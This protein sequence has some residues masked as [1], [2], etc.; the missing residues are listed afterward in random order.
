MASQSIY[1]FY[2]VLDDYKPVMWRRFQ[3]PGNITVARLAYIVMTLFEMT[4]SHLFAVEVPWDENFYKEIQKEDPEMFGVERI[5]TGI[6]PVWRY[7][8]PDL[9]MNIF[10][11]SEEVRVLDA[12]KSS[13]SKAV[14]HSG[15]KLNLNYDFGDNWRVSLT[16][17]SVTQDADLP[18]N[19]LPRVLEGAGFGIVEDCGGV[20]G[21]TELAAAFKK[22][23][24]ALY[25][26]LRKWLSTDDLD[27]FAF[28]I[29][30]M[31]FRLKKLPRIYKQAYENRMRPTQRSIDLIERKYA[32]QSKIRRMP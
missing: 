31:N 14:R 4:A 32:N 22:K 29:N 23:K 2:A 28:D 19:E 6:P 26:E 30:D 25:Q 10:E 27:M 20:T 15:D 5:S 7:E 18:G 8:L 13:M 17:E 16:L 11:D 24:G 1:Q 12:T 21:L 9:E 3:V